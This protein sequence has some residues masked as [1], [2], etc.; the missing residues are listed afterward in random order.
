MFFL[1]NVESDVGRFV[2]ERLTEKARNEQFVLG[3]SICLCLKVFAYILG[4]L[5]DQ[6]YRCCRGQIALLTSL[7]TTL[8]LKY[9]LCL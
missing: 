9:D 2:F 3:L 8:L 4:N 6:F 7:H 5:E 1:L